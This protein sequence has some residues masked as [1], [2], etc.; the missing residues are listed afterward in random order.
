MKKQKL[1]WCNYCKE[2]SVKVKVYTRKSDNTRQ[3]VAF[4][5]NIGCG[6]KQDLPFYKIKEYK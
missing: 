5:L 6:Y 2:Y 3:R 4:C 1:R